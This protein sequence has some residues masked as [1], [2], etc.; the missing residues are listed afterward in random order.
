MLWIR[1]M[2]DRSL[3]LNIAIESEFLIVTSNW[4][5]SL[6]EEGKNFLKQ[7][8]NVGPCPKRLMTFWN[9]ISLISAFFIILYMQQRCLYHLLDLS[10]SRPDSG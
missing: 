1:Q 5:Q 6:K 9:Q 2:K 10:D 7:F 3:L 8:D 4:N